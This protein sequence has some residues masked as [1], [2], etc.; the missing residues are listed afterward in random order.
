MKDSGRIKVPKTHQKDTL[1]DGSLDMSN[2]RVY[3]NTAKK[4]VVNSSCP[5]HSIR[6]L[7]C[8]CKRDA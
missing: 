8:K 3:G 1:F 5:F 4:G 2:R 7:K 6:T